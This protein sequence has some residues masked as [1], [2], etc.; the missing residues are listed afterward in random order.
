MSS[1]IIVPELGESIVD[2]RV[3]RWLKQEGEVVA[4]GDPLV[5][6]ETDKID[7]EVAAP[8]AG[9]L[10]RIDRKDGDD[11]K[12]G[13]VLG[14]VEDASTRAAPSGPAP[15]A[16]AEPGAPAEPAAAAAAEPG[17]GDTKATPSA[18]KLARQHQV[19][20][21]SVRGTGDGGRV[22]RK[23]VEAHVEGQAAPAA[24]APAPATPA[25]DPPSPLRPRRSP[26]GRRNRRWRR[27]R[28]P[29]RALPATG[30]R[31]ACA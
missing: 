19:D 6:L 8:Q 16:G 23:D 10:A 3:A 30:R 7:V 31:S 14:V 18:R 25:T 1:N 9:V 5:E 13:E 17:D 2:A 29:R 20:L 22:T 24:P 4:V 28:R 15:S 27:V 21:A 26:P 12:I 11:V